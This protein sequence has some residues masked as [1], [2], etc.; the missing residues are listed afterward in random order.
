M[1]PEGRL[2]TEG[3][4]CSVNK[5]VV[6]LIKKLGVPLVLASIKNAYLAKPKWR[7]SVFRSTVTVKAEE[8]IFPEA[9]EK[10]TDE[11]LYEKI[12]SALKSGEE[13]T[14]VYKENGRAKG[15]EKI[16]YKCPS[17]GKNFDMEGD[18]NSL[19]CRSCGRT[20]T[21]KNDY[22]FDS[23]EFKTIADYYEY[24][25]EE[26][27][28]KLSDLKIEEFVNTKI[29]K[30]GS[31]K[32]D[33][34]EGVF[35]LTKNGVSYKSIVSD[36]GFE[37]PLSKLEAIAYSAGEEFEMY[38]GDRLHYFYPKKDRTVC[39]RVALLYDLLKETE[40]KNE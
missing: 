18:N 15:L 3:K 33:K 38:D 26:E 7:K 34:D 31:N 5:T 14:A 37:K 19:K 22:T 9:I 29:F 23:E 27:R 21:L 17:C 12:L 35:T 11:A 28:K 6:P 13:S 32:Y 4:L 2:T 30:K 25:K 8:I 1:F 40:L 20:F 24:V 36:Y 39:V 10:M 16:L